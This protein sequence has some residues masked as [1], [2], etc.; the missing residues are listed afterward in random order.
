M[1][2]AH[3]VVQAIMRSPAGRP[4]AVPVTD[5]IVPGYSAVIKQPMDLSTVASHIVQGTYA[6]LGMPLACSEALTR[7]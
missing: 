3:K 1:A 2:A 4:F 6:G 7:G 5:A